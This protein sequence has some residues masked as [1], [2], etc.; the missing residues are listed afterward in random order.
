M[1]RRLLRAPLRLLR[2]RSVRSA[3]R[4]LLRR[5]ATVFM[6]HRFRQPDLGVEGHDP[7][8]VRTLLAFLRRERYRLVSLRSVVDALRAGEPLDG[9]VA[10][11]IDDGYADQADVAGPLFAEQDCPVTTFVTT[12]FLDRQLWMW[13][14]KIEHAF[15][16]TRASALELP[17]FSARWQHPGERAE[18]AFAA[19]EHCKRLPEA[20]KGPFVDALARRLEVELPLAAPARY[21]P[22]SWD[23]ARKW[24]ERG[25]SFGP[26]TLTHAILSLSDAE[27]SRREIEGSLQR[28]RQELRDPDPIF[29]YPNGQAED[30]GARE[31]ATLGALGFSAA[32]TGVPGHAQPARRADNLYHLRRFSFPDQIDDLLQCVSGF[33]HLKSQLRA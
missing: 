10:F 33:E 3:L 26:H 11:T 4:P 19:V 15:G 24:E 7:D 8:S 29:C 18:A 12:G 30:F 31:C 22:M 5:R 2:L 20:Q 28:L 27:Q 14:D 16:H 13:W 1:S 25:M 32:V 23:D 17:G 6:L 21:A 9:A